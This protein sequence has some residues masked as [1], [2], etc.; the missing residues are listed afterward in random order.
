MTSPS[1]LSHGVIYV[2][3]ALGVLITLAPFALGLLTSF[4]SAHQFATGTP[5][6][7]PRPPMNDAGTSS[8]RTN[9]LPRAGWTPS[10]EK[11]PMVTPARGTRSGSAPSWRVAVTRCTRFVMIV[12]MGLVKKAFLWQ[13]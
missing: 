12:I 7:W 5:L 8:S 2:G 1:R 6:Q 9:A 4:T 3:L 13:D 10:T 11:N